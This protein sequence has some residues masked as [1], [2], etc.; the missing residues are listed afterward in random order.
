MEA[1]DWLYTPASLAPEKSL[2]GLEIRVKVKRKISSPFSIDY[3]TRTSALALSRP[4]FVIWKHVRTAIL[5]QA[6]L[7]RLNVDQILCT[8]PWKCFVVIDG[9]LEPALT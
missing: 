9:T 8:L 3:S 6:L 5:M 1:S 7:V 2:V 4:E